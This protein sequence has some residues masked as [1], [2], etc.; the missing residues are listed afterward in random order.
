ML[1]E[2]EFQRLG[3]SETIKLD[4]RVVAACNVDL[5]ERIRKGKFREDLFY[6]LNVV[7][8]R[9]PALRERARDLPLLVAH[10]LDKVCAQEGFRSKPWPERRWNP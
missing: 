6:R 2:R 1:Q 5:E 7:P 10:F 4:V 8:I 3:S 9:M